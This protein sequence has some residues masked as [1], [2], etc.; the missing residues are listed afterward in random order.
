MESHGV[1]GAIQV[2]ETT[3][4]RLRDRY[5][6]EERGAVEIKGKGAMHTY[7]LIDKLT[8]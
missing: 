5:A 6:F 4:R 7:L 8:S 3:Y 1:G 2:T